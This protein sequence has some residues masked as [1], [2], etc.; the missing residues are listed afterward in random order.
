MPLHRSVRLLADAGHLMLG[1][2]LKLFLRAAVFLIVVSLALILLV[3]R[4]SAEFVISVLSLMVGLLL[5]GLTLLAHWW[6][7]R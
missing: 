1:E 6:G 4:D 2:G 3:P 5:L 7:R